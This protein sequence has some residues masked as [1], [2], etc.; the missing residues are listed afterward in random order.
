MGAAVAFLGR[1]GM[2]LEERVKNGRDE[3]A[4]KVYGVKRGRKTG[5]FTD[6]ADCR[7]AIEGFPGAVYKGFMTV[8]EAQAWLWGKGITPLSAAP[9][10]G[11]ET[12]TLAFDLDAPESG[13][14]EGGALAARGGAGAGVRVGAAAADYTVYTDGSCLK[15]PDG[16]GGFAAVILSRDG[17]VREVVGGEPHTTNNRMELRAGIEAL[18]AVPEGATLEF[19]TDSQY[20]QNAFVKRWL[21]AWQRRGW[22]T[23]TGTPVKNQD[24]WQ[25]LKAECERRTVRFHWVKGH[26]GHRYNERCDALAR[27]E[28]LRQKADA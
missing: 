26:A 20:L 27:Q 5:L 18:R 25:A 15:N 13:Q 7:E 6:W 12:M 10:R 3:M 17:S 22:V 1:Y 8:A 28:A 14:R 19:Y 16:P 21:S 9:S 4:K 23:A 11:A 2:I 24:L